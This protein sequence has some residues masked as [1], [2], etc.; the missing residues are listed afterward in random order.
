MEHISKNN[1]LETAKNRLD[2]S[3]LTYVEGTKYVYDRVLSEQTNKQLVKYIPLIK[4]KIGE[5]NGY[6]LRYKNLM[7]QYYWL[8][9]EFIPS[10][11]YEKLCM[12]NGEKTW[13]QY[14]NICDATRSYLAFNFYNDNELIASISIASG[15][16]ATQ[17]TPS[18]IGY[19]F[20]GW[21][22]ENGGNIFFDF[23]TPISEDTNVYTKYTLKQYEIRFVLNNGEE[24]IV[25][26]VNYGDTP[27]ISDPEKEGYTFSG[28][29]PEIVPVTKDTTY[30]A[31]YS[32]DIY[33]VRF[34]NIE[35][36]DYVLD[37]Y[38]NQPINGGGNVYYLIKT[39]T[40]G[41][42]DQSIYYTTKP[43]YEHFECVAEEGSTWWLD[44]EG[45]SIPVTAFQDITRDM[46]VFPKLTK[47]KYTVSFLDWD[48]TELTSQTVEY[49]NDAIAPSDPLRENYTFNGWDKSYTGIT[50]DTIIHARYVGD[51]ILVNYMLPDT[52]GSFTVFSSITISYGSTAPTIDSPKT[53]S[54]PP[55]DYG[56]FYG[57]YEDSAYTTPF[58][59][60]TL[61]QSDTEIYGKWKTEFEVSFYNWDGTIVSGNTESGFTNPVYVGYGEDVSDDKLDL[62]ITYMKDK[63]GYDFLGWNKSTT[64]ITYDVKITAVFDNTLIC[65]VRFINSVDGSV[66]S[67][68]T[69]PYASTILPSS[70]PEAPE[71]PNMN[72]VNWDG[73]TLGIYNDVDV[74]AIYEYVNVEVQFI[75]YNGDVLGSYTIKYND[76]GY[77]PDN[78][79]VPD[80]KVRL[81]VEHSPEILSTLRFNGRYCYVRDEFDTENS[82]ITPEK[83]VINTYNVQFKA[84]YDVIATEV[85]TF[86]VKFYNYDSA[87]WFTDTV[88]Y[89]TVID[90]AYTQNI[91]DV[92]VS[93]GQVPD[94]NV[95]TFYAW[96][97]G[98]GNEYVLG[99]NYLTVTQD[100][101]IYAKYKMISYT[102]KFYVQSNPTYYPEI[103]DMPIQ[104]LEIEAIK[105]TAINRP[106]CSNVPERI[107]F[108]TF[109]DGLNNRWYTD[110]ACTTEW[111][112]KQDVQMQPV[113]NP[114]LVTEDIILY[115]KYVGIQYHLN[116]NT[117]GGS[118]IVQETYR[119]PIPTV[120]PAN[121]TKEDCT[122]IGWYVDDGTFVNEFTFEQPL[123]GDTTIYAKWFDA[124]EENTIL[125][126][127]GNDLKVYIPDMGSAHLV[128]EKCIWDMSTGDGI[129]VY[130][131]PIVTFNIGIL[132]EDNSVTVNTEIK[133]N[134]QTITIPKAA[135]DVVSGQFEDCRYLY[136]INVA[137]D[138]AGLYVSED[139]V[140][141][142][143]I[144][145]NP[146]LTFRYI[147]YPQAKTDETFTIVGGLTRQYIIN[148]LCFA[149]C[150]NLKKVTINTSRTVPIE[151]KAFLNCNN[152]NE[153]TITYIGDAAS[154]ENNSFDGVDVENCKLYVP[155]QSYDSYAEHTV[156][157]QFDIQ[158]YGTVIYT[159]DDTKL[160][161]TDDILTETIVD[162]ILS[163]NNCVRSDIVKIEIGNNITN[164][165]IYTFRDCTNLSSVT[166]GSNVKTIGE[167]AFV[168][169][170]S[171]ISVTIPDSVTTIEQSAFIRNTS[172]KTVSFGYGLK[173]IDR[174]AF[175]QCVSLES[176]Y[177]PFNISNIDESAFDSC[178][179]LQAIVCDRITPPTVGTT[180]FGNTGDCPIYVPCESLSEYQNATNWSE[181]SG[182]MVCHGTKLFLSD[183]N[184]FVVTG[185]TLTEDVVSFIYRQTLVACEI[186]EEVTTVS[187][188]TFF[189]CQSL[190]SVTIPN[191]VTVIGD[192]AF[193][194]C[195]N[196]TSVTIP[197]SIINIGIQVFQYCTSL[198]SINIPNNITS[199]PERI[200]LHCSNLN[201]INIHNGIISIDDAAFA[202][203]S[204][205][206]SITIP[207]SVNSIGEY[208]FNG[209]YRLIEIICES[210]TPPNI[211]TNAFNGT[212]NCPIYVPCNS[213]E[214]YKAATNWSSY[215]DRIK[216]KQ[217]NYITFTS[218]ED[219]S[220]IG[221]N[222]KNSNQTLE[223]TF[224]PELENSWVNF[225]LDEVT[226]GLGNGDSVYIRGNLDGANV[227]DDYTNFYINGNVSVSGNINSLWNHD[228][229]EQ[230]LHDFC[231]V[232]L[233]ENCDGLTNVSGLTLGTSTS[234]LSEYC[235]LNMFNNC[236]NLETA[237]TL[238]A[239]TLNNYCYQNMF[240]NCVRLEIAPELPALVLADGCY[241]N[242][243][244]GC[245]NLT[246]ISKLPATALTIS[247]Y[248]SMFQSCISLET[249]PEL[250]A[251]TLVDYCYQNM[252]YGCANLNYIKCLAIDGI[253]ENSST[254]EWVYG[255]SDTGRFVKNLLTEYWDIC[256]INGIPC[257]WN[258]YN[259]NYITF[260]ALEDNSVISINSMNVY[261]ELKYTYNTE[262][263][264]SWDD[265][266]GATVTLN[267]GESIYVRGKLTN[268]DYNSYTNFN[269]TG[270][271]SVSG[272]LNNIWNYDELNQDLIDTCGYKL[273][274]RCEGLVDASNLVLGTS[275]T[276][277]ASYCYDSMFEGC[278]NLTEPPELPATELAI[279]CYESMFSGCV[280]L[281][282]APALPA[283]TL[284]SHC[285]NDM[286]SVCRNLTEAPDLHA[287]ELANSCYRYMFYGCSSLTAAPELP[288][289]TLV[290][291]CYENMFRNCSS[292]N[293]IKCLAIN[294]INQN[295]STTNWVNGVQTNSG[296]FVK[297]PDA[298]SWTIGIDGIPT[299]WNVED[300]KPQNYITFTAL[301]D[302]VPISLN[303]ISSNHKLLYSTDNCET[304]NDFTT[305]I[306]ITLSNSGDTCYVAGMLS[307][308]NNY[309]NYTRFN[310]PNR[311]SISGNLNGL[312]NGYTS[313]NTLYQYCAYNLFN[314]CTGLIDASELEL[315]TSATTLANR[316]YWGMFYGC[317]NLIEAPDLH[318]TE[319]A[320]RC[321]ESMFSG[322]VGLTTAPE[323]PAT[324]L[325]EGCYYGMFWNCS[326][327]TAAPE[328]PATTLANY[329]YQNMFY[330]CGSLNYIK[331]L[332]VDGINQN[333][334][335]SNWVY[336]VQE[337]STSTFVKNPNTSLAT[338]GSGSDGIPNQWTI[339]DNT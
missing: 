192:E 237:P 105:N 89:G 208:A 275:Q 216:C 139:G 327:L 39:E 205:L 79:S 72:F 103:I 260:T 179:S 274:Y 102:V 278:T 168:D 323:L 309:S 65:L 145:Y 178:H 146:R 45:N 204:S 92:F 147:C 66:I 54:Y 167:S 196:L 241:S 198:V 230:A 190:T 44:R 311:L 209:C 281:T 117:N 155:C 270:K 175:N 272:N 63:P 164:I 35:N 157:G 144:A 302:N 187:A 213:V 55:E 119:Y 106:D 32:R 217:N 220:I 185:N 296:T 134:L 154:V 218:Y 328:L 257:G 186:D 20:N 305:G 228:D 326:S 215:E 331:C 312:W 91:L 189:N 23:T 188:R 244:C 314:G 87:Y 142:K 159:Y 199:I 107:Y 243:F 129:L 267:N 254:E 37:F 76:N 229:L 174:L 239:T 224:T 165:E 240:Y 28:W 15:N 130:D 197:D 64:G 88:L 203:C 14:D 85:T 207:D 82:C 148:E 30:E 26:L 94:L 111:I 265:L 315:G 242:M 169:C 329:C 29:Y 10:C 49:L 286:F 202:G 332:A 176:L 318:A 170:S 43:T 280:G 322:C 62:I 112:F 115:G 201:S 48:N 297:H 162:N 335:T 96:A 235:Y 77:T 143:N 248:E 149:N 334:S 7:R 166:I 47:K 113:S 38:D 84:Q 261:Q 238:P 138:N 95:Q 98:N 246:T 194:S 264:D 317:S 136:A 227:I 160:F 292:L 303:R 73:N 6:I 291:G 289:T 69:V 110:S 294:G 153:I 336:G 236:V 313:V 279:C 83:M 122:F 140:L 163:D 86:N 222:S 8:I 42:H 304:W 31:G 90:E 135:T 132:N 80:L 182:R 293:Y 233:F 287:T 97:D 21:V 301:E 219:G 81:D 114:D 18:K 247:C 11:S 221:L 195:T 183:G 307:G 53:E 206:M 133:R 109:C 75:D 320:N 268:V 60:T 22:T 5:Q 338:W 333:G 283:T 253:N 298:T 141:I 9:N 310:L 71:V 288:A 128:Q 256:D 16:T 36:P 273:F 25:I 250:P 180:I 231:G 124:P 251:T 284:A 285:Y 58:D 223:Y 40:H 255:V 13:L 101:S 295:D 214:L 56:V 137:E 211:E 324:T 70:Y 1:S 116:Y 126:N 4:T 108:E 271:M 68:T 232:S 152:L 67:S 319:L 249:A 118:A 33:I 200:F 123:T 173:N 27:I 34:F 59:Y 300:A 120:R 12:R 210:V 259:E 212:N 258:V 74:Y 184:V 51:D 316:C 234:L 125:Y 24:D 104:S 93:Q 339:I 321:Y 151:E 325:A 19:Y 330:G 50:N 299:N 282:T 225:N 78:I 177:L 99:Q 269:I 57:W 266:S 158:C 172:L 245:T 308:N 150:K 193:A 61:L 306:T 181:Y 226:I 121:P 156:W 191:S 161:I 52:G 46:D 100:V 41:L 171:L 263:D 252:F 276:Q 131:A 17:F 2:I 277:L 290:D 262:D 127:A 3:G 337:V